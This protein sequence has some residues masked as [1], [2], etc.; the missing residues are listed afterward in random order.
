[1]SAK[2]HVLGLCEGHLDNVILLFFFL[3]GTPIVY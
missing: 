1:M 2:L 3:N